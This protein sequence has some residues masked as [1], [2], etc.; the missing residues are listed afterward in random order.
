MPTLGSKLVDLE[1][2]DSSRCVNRIQSTGIII[3]L[4]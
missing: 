4:H 2:K 3:Y 1:D